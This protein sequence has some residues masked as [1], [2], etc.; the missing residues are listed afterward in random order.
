V[1]IDLHT[2][3]IPRDCFDMVDDEGRPFGPSVRRD[4]SGREVIFVDGVSLGPLLAPVTD[5]MVRLKDMDRSGIDMQALSINPSSVFNDMDPKAATALYRRYNDA[6]AEVVSAHPD[7]FIGL[8]TVALQDVDLAVAELDR[9]VRT[10]GLRGVQ[11]GSNIAGKN[12]DERKFWPF[13]EKA[14]ELG[15][16]IF[17]HPYHVLAPE[18][19]QRYWLINLVGNPIDTAIAVGSLVFGGVIESFPRLKFVIAHGGGAAPYLEGR[20]SHG[21]QAV[22]EAHSV[23]LTPKTYL[24][25]MYFDTLTHSD[26]ARA[27]LVG[28]VG[29]DH[30][31]LG[32][33]YPFQMGDADPVATVRNDSKL[34]SEE[35]AV[36]LDQSAELLLGSSR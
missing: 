20:W 30:V 25:R 11:I 2:H 21:H 18:R 22:A 8:A 34:T 15:T 35:K 36:I 24:K 6:I 23:P 5:P 29:A 28:L 3:F 33:D 31:V 1:K 32:S 9:A 10:Q 13:Y 16:L 12:L 7:R 26:L 27:Y 19:M 14:Q 4:A 17:M